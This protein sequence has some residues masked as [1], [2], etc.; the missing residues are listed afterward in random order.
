VS[1]NHKS[2]SEKIKS[3]PKPGKN[4]LE[5]DKEIAP[6]KNKTKETGKYFLAIRNEEVRLLQYVTEKTVYG[7][8]S[9]YT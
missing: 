8:Y 9:V 6:V 1:E 5:W 2:V 7:P 4:G 3:L